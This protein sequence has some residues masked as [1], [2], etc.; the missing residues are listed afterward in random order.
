VLGYAGFMRPRLAASSR[1]AIGLLAFVGVL[2][3]HWLAYFVSAPARVEREHLLESTGHGDWSL[4]GA[5]AIGAF[6]AALASIA[7][8]RLRQGG[9]QP[10]TITVARRL[11]LLQTMG[12]LALEAAERAIAGG[13]AMDSLTEPVVAL[14]VL[15]Q[16]LVAFAAAL[17]SRLIVEAVDRFAS[18]RTLAQE[19][20]PRR[21]RLW[22]TRATPRRRTRVGSEAR[23][24]RGPPSTLAST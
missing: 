18:G 5:V 4:A 6:T 1:V 2:S 7:W 16:V 12:F 19:R 10:S 23:T 15:V 3:A 17:F 21:A 22:G 14:G 13:S 11:A 9:P 24:L 20:A 8:R